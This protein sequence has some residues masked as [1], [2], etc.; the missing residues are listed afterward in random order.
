MPRFAPRATAG[1]A[2]LTA[3]LLALTG[4]SSSSGGDAPADGGDVLG[5]VDTM[6]GTIEVPQPQDDLRVVALG[7]SDAEM[8]LALGVKPIAV[9]DWQGFGADE[10]GVGPWAADLFGDVKPEVLERADET[11][12]YE[13]I[14]VLDP[15]LILNVRS[16]NDEKEFKRL[17]DIAPTV[18]A[19]AGTAAFATSWDVQ[20]ESVAAALGKSDEGKAII[21]KTRSAI[22][23]AA[24]EHPEFQGL[25]TAAGTKFGDAYGAYLAGDGRFDILADLGFSN[26]PGV[27][28]LEPT[29]FFTAV[30][31]EQ[32]SALDADV[33]VILPIGF[34]L[35]EAQADPLLASLAAVKEGRA[36]FIDP[37]SE[38]SGAYS[39][40]SPLAIPVVLDQLVPQLADAAAKVAR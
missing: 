37:D 22:S 29:G 6:F 40:A 33:P 8:A 38:L 30:S 3:A 7:W 32:V 13:Q 4:C 25:T 28:A 2:V 36:V 35:A 21:E 9:F 11:L 1:V 20:L 12:N 26:A 17:K 5:T 15:D 16:A 23:A 14:E 18:Y 34:T 24:A 31:A 27:E 19:P 10:K 39:A